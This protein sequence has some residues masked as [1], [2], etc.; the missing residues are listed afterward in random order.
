MGGGSIQWLGG[1]SLL[2]MTVQFS[3]VSYLLYDFILRD[4]REV[5]LGR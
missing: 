1:S 4:G 2:N 5:S 3:F